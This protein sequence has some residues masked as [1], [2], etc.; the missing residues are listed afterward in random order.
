[1]IVSAGLHG[2]G[3]LEPELEVMKPTVKTFEFPP[4]PATTTYA[5]Y[6]VEALKPVTA[7]LPGPDDISIPVP[8]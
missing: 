6:E 5:V 8:C 1:M 3:A 2:V 7:K 4:C